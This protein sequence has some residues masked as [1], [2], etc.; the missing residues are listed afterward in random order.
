MDNIQSYIN[1]LPRT[2]LENLPGDVLVQNDYEPSNRNK[3]TN[4]KFLFILNRC[5]T[6]MYFCQ[7]AN[8]PEL[9]MGV[10]LQSNPTSMDIKRPG[11]RHVFGDL[12]T[13]F[14]V[15]EEM[16]N[17]LE[18]YNWIRDLST[19]TYAV[20]DILKEKQ[21]ISSAMMYVLSSAYRPI[22]KITFYDVFPTSLTG[23]D[24][25]SSLPDVGAVQAAATFNFT[26]YEIQGITAS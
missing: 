5:P 7:R 13:S 23:I 3:L 12:I 11:T 8:I 6:F 10:S 4:N 26:R 9:S 21:K 16:K 15:D 25:D 18:I 24:F 1:N 22:V 20:G 17:W 19:D 2:V 14:V